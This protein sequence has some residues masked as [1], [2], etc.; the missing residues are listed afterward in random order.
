[1][2]YGPD[3]CGLKSREDQETSL[4]QCVQAGHDLHSHPIRRVLRVKWPERE[5]DHPDPPSVGV[6]LSRTVQPVLYCGFM[7]CKRT[8]QSIFRIDVI[9][10][11]AN[12]V[13]I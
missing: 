9:L 5:A 10:S 1:V 8:I 4:F 6:R 13:I 2:G 11:N 3:G 7:A 12:I